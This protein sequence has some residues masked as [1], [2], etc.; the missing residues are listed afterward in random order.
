MATLNQTR[1]NISHR[2]NFYTKVLHKYLLKRLGSLS[3]LLTAVA[4][5][6]TVVI[7]YWRGLPLSYELAERIMLGLN[8]VPEGLE[9]KVESTSRLD[10]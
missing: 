1:E 9:M 6:R 10:Q 7:F 2:K 8:K 3:Y 4:D 5:S